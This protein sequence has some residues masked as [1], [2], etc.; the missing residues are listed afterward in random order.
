MSDELYPNRNTKFM[1]EVWGTTS[2]TSDYWSLPVKKVLQEIE[3]DDLTA[4]TDNLDT[5]GEI[6]DPNP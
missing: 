3:N 5:D 1:R 4:K 2:L 6:F